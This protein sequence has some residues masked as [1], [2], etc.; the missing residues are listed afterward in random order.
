MK[1]LAANRR[2][3]PYVDVENWLLREALP[4]WAEHG[5]DRLSGG[6]VEQLSLD[7]GNPNVDFKRTRVTARQI[8]VF[9][10]AALLGFSG[11]AEI[12]RHGFDFL[13]R[14]AWLGDAGGWARRLSR[15]GEVLDPAPDLYD[16]A[17]V[18]FALG[19][20]ERATGSGEARMWSLRTLEFID[21]QMR[22]PSGLGF[23]EQKPQQ[24]PRLQNPHMHLLEAALCNLEAFGDDRFRVLAD[25]IVELFREHFFDA[26]TGTLGEYFDDRLNRIGDETGRQ[27]E[28]GHHFEWAWILAWYQRL[29]GRDMRAV[30]RP[31]VE[32][33]ER[34]GV[35]RRSGATFALVRDDGVALDKSE[36]VWPATE[37]IQ[38]AVAM[39]ELEGRDPSTVFMQSAARLLRYHLAHTPSGTWIDVFAPDGTVRV[40]KI[41]ASTLYHLMIAFTEMLRI[42][43]TLVQASPA[44]GLPGSGG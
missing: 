1:E 5:V 9:S 39:F 31:L 32:F 24:G 6:F 40:D 10:H 25:E 21:R 14:N 38:A 12:A 28:P 20:Y 30:I 15:T 36:R 11:G 26:A 35:D 23:L 7:G 19:W 17:F 42:E 41:P 8:Y 43:G 13:T 37:R 3:A 34:Y 33:A 44:T 29:S 4:F 16:L 2:K 18:L 22:H 27:I